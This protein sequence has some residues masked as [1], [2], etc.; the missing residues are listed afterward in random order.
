M[1]ALVLI[2]IIL[3]GLFLPIYLAGDLPSGTDLGKYL[4]E[5]Y[6]ALRE[7]REG[8]MP[9]WDPFLAGGVPAHARMQQ[10]TFY[11]TTWLLHRLEPAQF[12]IALYLIHLLIAA[13]FTAAYLRRIGVGWKGQALGAGVYVLSR[14][15]VDRIHSGHMNLICA[16]AWIPAF[17]FVAQGAILRQG[18]GMAR[19][20]AGLA[21][22]LALQL[23]AGR[24]EVFYFTAGA[25]FLYLWVGLGVQ[26]GGPAVRRGVGVALAA[27]VLFL[28][29]AACQFLPSLELALN[30]DRMSG[31]PGLTL[32]NT[33]L[34]LR[35]LATILLPETYG[36]PVDYTFWGTGD[37]RNKYPYFGTFAAVLTGLAFFSGF[38]GWIV[39][40][41]LIFGVA[42]YAL[43]SREMI[44]LTQYLW[45]ALPGFSVI[46]RDLDR[47]QCI[48]YFG[49]AALSGMALHR[50]FDDPDHAPGMASWPN[51]KRCLWAAAVVMVGVGLSFPLA[52]NFYDRVVVPFAEKKVAELNAQGRGRGMAAD[53]ARERMGRYYSEGFMPAARWAGSLAAAALVMASLGSTSYRRRLGTA[54]LALGLLESTLYFK[55]F[56]LP[57]SPDV[58]RK[59]TPLSEYVVRRQGDFRVGLL[60]QSL[61]PRLAPHYGIRGAIDYGPAH[62]LYYKRLA[63]VGGPPPRLMGSGYYLDAAV[64][65][66][67]NVLRLLGAGLLTTTRP[68]DIPGLAFDTA[69]SSSTYRKERYKD[70][71]MIYEDTCYVYRVERPLKRFAL[72]AHIE[73]P[74]VD[75]ATLQILSS[76]PDL[77]G[78]TLYVSPGEDGRIQ[79]DPEARGEIGLIEEAPS[80]LRISGRSDGRMALFVG[81]SFYPGWEVR[82]NGARRPIHRAQY[83]FRA[84]EVPAG[85]WTVEMIYRPLSVRA[86]AGATL[87]GLGIVAAA[88]FRRRKPDGC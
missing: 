15:Y 67:V 7:F 25:G 81:D 71:Q 5:K 50:L 27:T 3:V 39:K 2:G 51:R 17:F 74:S 29:L 76:D 9:L 63:D 16:S 64:L 14:W 47:I 36:N 20:A 72:Y 58:Y 66:S 65:P 37:F 73:H 82:V 46:Y 59:P 53:E 42:M 68:L 88:F 10:S 52:E 78:T 26:G 21:V 18:R 83:A 23:V 61:S 30:S 19:A 1:R 70:F 79:A 12:T 8:R 38:R 45:R 86:G 11:P 57:V 44:G 32:R 85:E 43:I 24:P 56:L 22:I 54:A 87:A 6:F 62:V 28:L 49:A 55:R 75:D 77:A 60:H 80:K 40:F 33:S 84:V 31:D 35:N 34:P 69:F 13:G 48:F 4:A 41:W